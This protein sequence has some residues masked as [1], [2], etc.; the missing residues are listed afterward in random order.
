MKRLGAVLALLATA[1]WAGEDLMGVI[2]VSDAGSVNNATTGYGSAGCATRA[3]VNGAG[4][5]AQSFRI[6]TSA[7]ISIQ[8]NTA[9]MVKVNRPAADAGDGIRVAV[10]QFLTSS[11]AFGGVR[12]SLT[13][14]GGTY[15]GGMV[16]IAPVAGAAQAECKVFDRSGVE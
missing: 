2:L 3:S 15:A 12:V 8:C 11:T 1:A 10:D 4:A 5:C 16:S 9:A 13:P 6:P 14:D 7:L